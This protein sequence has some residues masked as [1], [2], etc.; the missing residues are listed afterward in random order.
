MTREI[1]FRVWDKKKKKMYNP[2]TF[3]EYMEEV[4]EVDDRGIFYYDKETEDELNLDEMELMQYA[5]FP[6]TDGKEIYEGDILKFKPVGEKENIGKVN[7][8]AGMFMVTDKDDYDYEIGLVLAD[9]L[10]VI[11]NI[12]E[13]DLD[14]ISM[15]KEHSKTMEGLAKK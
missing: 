15:A 8:L 6:D 7:F 1:K 9:Y 10:K 14:V 3:R 2:M 4:F 11:G 5:G 12:Y 13:N